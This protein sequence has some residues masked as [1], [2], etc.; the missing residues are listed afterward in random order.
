MFG[1]FR[2]PCGLSRQSGLQAL[3]QAH[4]KP[5]ALSGVIAGGG[6]REDGPGRLG[7]FLRHDPADFDR[8]GKH[9]R[10]PV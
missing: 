2:D 8:H 5:I 3:C 7:V 9:R 4:G 6:L 10:R 1:F